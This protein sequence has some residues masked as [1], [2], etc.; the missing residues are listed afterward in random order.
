MYH[1]D[2]CLNKSM[3]LRV[4]S[5]AFSLLYLDLL[6]SYKVKVLENQ[7][8]NYIFIFVQHGVNPL[9]AICISY[10]NR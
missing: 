3:L 1:K 10:F 9:M 2:R 5:F 4:H 7:R 6:T 8:V